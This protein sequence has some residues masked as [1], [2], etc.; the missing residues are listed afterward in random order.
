MSKTISIFGTG[1]H[2]WRVFTD[3][4]INTTETINMFGLTVDYGGSGGIW[5]RLQEV[6]N[7]SLTRNIF[8]EAKPV[9]PWGD[10][11][12][13]ISYFMSYRFTPE[14]AKCLD[15]RSNSLN[16]HLHNFQILSDY[17]ALSEKIHNGFEDFFRYSF[18]F[19]LQYKTKIGYS[20]KKEFCFGYP[21]QDFVFWNLG[22]VDDLNSFYKDHKILPQNLNLYFTANER[23]VLVGKSKNREYIGED[24]IDNA[25]EPIIPESLEIFT[26]NQQKITP[27]Q[28]L[29][30]RLERSDIIIFPTGSIT[31]W[32]P[33]VSVSGILELLQKYSKNGKLFWIVNLEKA[34]NECDLTE[35]INFL[36]ARSLK[37]KL[38][39]SVD[40][41]KYQNRENFHNFSKIGSG[42]DAY[43]VLKTDQNHHYIPQ[44][45]TQELEKM[46]NN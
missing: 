43:P 19:Y 9:L 8:N 23:E 14:V 4:I 11:N 41:E 42:I 6:D 15:F 17:L 37:P 16:S 12:K 18:D 13:I 24:Q 45:V 40:Y 22:R 35:Y 46:F 26:A 33:L 32:L 21:W 38:L 25:L 5:Y 31:N 36:E 2:G 29:F 7:F 10:F 44:S 30:Q 20:T 3:L 28:S 39:F 34:K 27:S 1:G